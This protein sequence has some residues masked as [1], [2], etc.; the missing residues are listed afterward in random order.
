MKKCPYC[1]E[2]I[3]DEAI[4]CRYCNR[5]LV[6][7]PVQVAIPKKPKSNMALYIILVIIGVCILLLVVTKFSSGKSQPSPTFSPQEDAWTAC[8]T[9]VEKKYGIS[10]LEAEKFNQNKIVIVENG[11]YYVEAFFAKY[12]TT[13]RCLIKHSGDK[14][15]A[16][17]VGPK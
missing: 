5:S 9:F 3:Q 1:A 2:E 8:I 15:I 12:S 17:F 10:F 11:D 6:T 13:Y 16:D 14:W 7:V 4:I